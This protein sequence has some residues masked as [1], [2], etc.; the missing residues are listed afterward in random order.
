MCTAD[1]RDNGLLRA[2]LS[3][4]MGA[5]L[6]NTFIVVGLGVSALGEVAIDSYY[7]SDRNSRVGVLFECIGLMAAAGWH[8]LDRVWVSCVPIGVCH[9]LTE[10][11]GWDGRLISSE[12]LTSAKWLP[13][14]FMLEMLNG[15]WSCFS[16]AS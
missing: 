4:W 9:G 11:I 16:N 3:S 15:M 7:T 12:V 5:S 10:C 6:I 1:V 13:T 2:K 8:G 14:V